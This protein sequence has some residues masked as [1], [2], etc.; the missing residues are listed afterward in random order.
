[1]KKQASPSANPDNQLGSGI[2]VKLTT[3]L[4]DILVSGNDSF[5]ESLKPS[6]HDAFKFTI[7][8][9]PSGVK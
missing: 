1:M 9:K 7:C 2:P 4:G 6:F 3:G 8:C 5:K